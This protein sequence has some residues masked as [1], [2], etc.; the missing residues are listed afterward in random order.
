MNGFYKICVH[1][2]VSSDLIFICTFV[3]QSTVPS[4]SIANTFLIYSCAVFIHSLLVTVRFNTFLKVYQGQYSTLFL[5]QTNR[6]KQ[7]NVLRQDRMHPLLGRFGLGCTYQHGRQ[8]CFDFPQVQRLPDFQRNGRKRPRGS[9]G[10]L[11]R[12]SELSSFPI[13]LSQSKSNTHDSFL[14]ISPPSLTR[15]LPSSRPL[16]RLLRLLRLMPSMMKSTLPA[17][18]K[19]PL[20][21]TAKSRTRFSSYTLR[22]ARSRLSRHREKTLRTRLPRS[23]PS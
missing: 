13:R 16:V 8:A 18:M 1:L 23:R 15:I 3:I 21:R 2:P 20:C 11:P 12:K 7:H 10:C 19:P 6:Q 5:S 17:A 9:P 22:P 14:M 4:Y